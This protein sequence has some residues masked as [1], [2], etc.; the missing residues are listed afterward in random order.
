MALRAY[1]TPESVLCDLEAG[2]KEDAL[3]QLVDALLAAKAI[4]S[5]PKAGLV[6]KEV[7]QRERQASTGIGRGIG[8]PHARSTHV[9]EI[10][11]AIGR[12][13]G[14]LDYGAIDGE[15]VWV[16]ILLVSPV[17][18]TDEHL[19]VMKTIVRMARDPYHCKRLH[20]CSTPQSFLDLIEELDGRLK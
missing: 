9:K 19:A 20:A 14:G 15:R 11:V 17:A 3:R 2:D 12:I 1:C 10:A 8:I 16:L 7:V 5:K 6:L 4:P 18:K 13:P